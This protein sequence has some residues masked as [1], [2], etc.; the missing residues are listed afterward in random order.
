MSALPA[1]Q[2]SISG[3]P[4]DPSQKPELIKGV[5]FKVETNRHRTSEVLNGIRRIPG[6]VDIDTRSSADDKEVS[7][8]HVS[9]GDVAQSILNMLRED[10]NADEEAE[11]T[12]D[13]E[14]G[15]DED[16]EE[17]EGS[18]GDGNVETDEDAEDTE[19][20]ANEE[21]PV[22]VQTARNKLPHVSGMV[23]IGSDGAHMDERH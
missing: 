9:D 2:A 1:P 10:A 17:G 4:E 18:E 12:D 21:S 11:D 13:G 8:V 16:D 3:P 5:T 15:E 7:T 6:V 23:G 20:V 22:E 14:E 19:D